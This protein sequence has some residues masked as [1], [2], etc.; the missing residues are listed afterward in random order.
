MTKFTYGIEGTRCHKRE[1]SETKRDL[2]ATRLKLQSSRKYFM[3]LDSE[4]EIAELGAFYSNIFYDMVLAA[5]RC[6]LLRE[7]RQSM[8]IENNTEERISYC[9]PGNF[10]LCEDIVC[11]FTTT[12]SVWETTYSY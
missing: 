5:R 1:T 12:I 6:T 7:K 11:S 2:G 9:G 4:L 3:E 8:N 10:H